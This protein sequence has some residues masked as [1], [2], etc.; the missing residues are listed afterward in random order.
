M[1]SNQIVINGSKEL[2]FEVG[3]TVCDQIIEIC[4]KADKGIQR[5]KRLAAKSWKTP[6]KEFKHAKAKKR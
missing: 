6:N 5:A 4:K 1:S 2:T 3:D